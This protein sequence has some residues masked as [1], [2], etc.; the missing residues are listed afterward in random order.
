MGFDE[1]WIDG[2]GNVIGILKGSGKGP[3]VMLN[4]HLDDGSG[5]E[6]RKLGTRSFWCRDRR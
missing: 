4:T 2:I 6:A 5:W 3:N 1:A